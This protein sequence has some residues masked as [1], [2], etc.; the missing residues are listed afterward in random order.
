MRVNWLRA[1]ARRDCWAEELQL[2]KNEMEWTV[3]GLKTK[4]AEWEKLKRCCENER[5]LRQYAAKQQGIWLDMAKKAENTFQEE[6]N[7]A[8]S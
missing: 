6:A 2:V 5:G 1:K 4:A 8:F 3:R 7:V